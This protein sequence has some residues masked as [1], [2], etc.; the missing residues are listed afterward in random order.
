MSPFIVGSLMKTQ[1]VKLTVFA[2]ILWVACGASMKAQNVDGTYSGTATEPGG[3]VHS[4]TDV[5][6]NSQATGHNTFCVGDPTNQGSYDWTGVVTP[7]DRVTATISGQVTI[8]NNG[9][10]TAPLTGDIY[11]DENGFL[12]LQWEATDPVGGQIGF[13]TLKQ[14]FTIIAPGTTIIQLLDHQYT[15]TPKTPFDAQSTQ[16]DPISW[17]LKL[18]YTTSGGVGP[19]EIEIP[20]FSTQPNVA[21][22]QIFK[23]EGGSLQVSASQDSSEVSEN[24][25]ISGPPDQLVEGWITARLM[26]LY[27]LGS[28]AGYTAQLLCDI[29]MKESSY[30]QFKRKNL[31]GLSALWPNENYPTKDVPAGAHI[32]LM[33]VATTGEGVT[34][35]TSMAVAFDWMV[36]TQKGADNFNNKIARTIAYQN[37]QQKMIEGL[38]SMT[39]QQIEDSALARYGGFSFQGE[40]L[41]Y[42]IPGQDSGKPVWVKNPQ[43]S[44]V[45][46]KESADHYIYGV[47]HPRFSIPPPSASGSSYLGQRSDIETP[48]VSVA[49]S[50]SALQAVQ[51]YVIA[52]MRSKL[53]NSDDLAIDPPKVLDYAY[54]DLTGNGQPPQLLCRLDYSGRGC[55]TVLAIIDRSHGLTQISYLYSGGG[56]IG[57]GELRDAIFDLNNDGKHQLIVAEPI[58]SVQSLVLPNPFFE[59]IYSFRDGK[60]VQSD[61]E[62]VAY[63]RDTVLPKLQAQLESMIKDPLVPEYDWSEREFYQMGLNA[64]RKEIQEVAKLL[65]GF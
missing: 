37:S 21:Q 29:A 22:N 52:V 60:F 11:V 26:A 17:T 50:D 65:S 12:I 61:A 33:Q 54:V 57:F 27:P 62:F 30:L 5:V 45:H 36:N 15:S 35:A 10:R 47:R 32:G 16:T 64:K 23:G 41:H 46:G 4:E 31:Y 51:Q 19:F 38:P 44:V 39:G 63:Y 40:A 56:W 43:D 2:V 34:S 6:S 53:K 28:Q 13:D 55:P 14:G 8:N 49:Q 3:C 58:E 20:P 1:S 18:S 24:E 42:W 25:I 48:G 7:I 59:H 9:T